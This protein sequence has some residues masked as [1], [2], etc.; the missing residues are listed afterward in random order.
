MRPICK[1]S[2]SQV[3]CTEHVCELAPSG[4]VWD[5][6]WMCNKCWLYHNN[7]DIRKA[8]KGAPTAECTSKGESIQ[9]NGKPKTRECEG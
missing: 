2:N 7:A 4:S 6:S 5:P 1:C 3:Q 8:W 9:V